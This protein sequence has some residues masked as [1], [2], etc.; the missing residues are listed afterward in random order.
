MPNPINI[1]K[2]G[3]KKS[4]EP[5]VCFIGRWDPQKRV[6]IFLELAQS[7]P[8]VKFVALGK[9]HSKATDCLLRKRYERAKNLILTG[10]VTE[11]EKSAIL[12]KSWIL[13]NTSIREGLPISF[14]EACAHRTAILSYVNPD[15]FASKF[16]AHVP[17]QNFVAGLRNL[18][19]DD[20]WKALGE[21]GYK[22]VLDTHE[23]SKVIDSH[24]EFYKNLTQ[25]N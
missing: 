20:R 7:F 1:P 12:E 8:S 4:D 19:K 9:S 14:I 17:D 15:D 5:T 13:I 21:A 23:T 11:E 2:R 16:G 24:L 6:D 18:L 25:K 22:Y 3:M 10:F